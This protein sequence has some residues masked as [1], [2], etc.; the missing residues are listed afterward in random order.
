MVLQ[1]E[2]APSDL[3]QASD[4]FEN[5]EEVNEDL[6]DL[7][8]IVHLDLSGAPPKIEFLKTRYNICN[9]LIS[10]IEAILIE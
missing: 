7:K 2:V 9:F 10:S 1:K 8:R 3:V 4:T 6:P 5:L